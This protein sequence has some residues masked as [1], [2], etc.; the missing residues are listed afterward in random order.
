MCLTGLKF[1][2]LKE[3]IHGLLFIYE[4]FVCF[5][6]YPFNKYP[7]F[8]LEKKI[9]GN[10]DFSHIATLVDSSYASIFLLKEM[11]SFPNAFSLSFSHCTFGQSSIHFQQRN[12]TSP[13]SIFSLFLPKQWKAC[14]CV[15]QQVIWILVGLNFLG[16]SKSFSLLVLLSY[17]FFMHFFPFI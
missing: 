7:S 15:R 14:V 3:R 6:F 8:Y 11:G 10:I 16:Y 17:R 9:K 1:T 12:P 4:A 13:L 5:P 2:L